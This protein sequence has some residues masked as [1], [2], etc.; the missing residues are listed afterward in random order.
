M[1][2]SLTATYTGIKI[3]I[4]HE[5]P[6]F[7]TTS[8]IILMLPCCLLPLA[9]L[10]P[11][12]LVKYSA[13]SLFWIIQEKGATDNFVSNITLWLWLQNLVFLFSVFLTIPQIYCYTMWNMCIILRYNMYYFHFTLQ[14][15]SKTYLCFSRSF[16]M[17]WASFSMLDGPGGTGSFCSK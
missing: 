1:Y 12:S 15:L 5:Y 9:V 8:K 7:F 16:S 4:G 17:P 11:H 14:E 10:L 6:S 3:L 2:V 13:H